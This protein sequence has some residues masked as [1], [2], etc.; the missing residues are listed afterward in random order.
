MRCEG[1]DLILEAI[2]ILTRPV[3]YWRW[4]RHRKR[5]VDWYNS[6][7]Y[8]RSSDVPCT[9]TERDPAD[10]RQDISRFVDYVKKNLKKKNMVEA[11]RRAFLDSDYVNP[12]AND[13]DTTTAFW[14][15]PKSVRDAKRRAKLKHALRRKV[16]RAWEEGV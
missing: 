1:V 6:R 10:V 4:M 3:R 11:S 8:G 14:L 13:E 2:E 16:P 12:L 15:E 7:S 5:C 9:W